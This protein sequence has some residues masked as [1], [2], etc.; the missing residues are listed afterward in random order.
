M[1]TSLATFCTSP[2]LYNNSSSN[3]WLKMTPFHSSN[4]FDCFWSFV[5]KSHTHTVSLCAIHPSSS[6]S[7]SA[8]VPGNSSVSADQLPPLNF[9]KFTSC[10]TRHWNMASLSMPLM[11]S[12]LFFSACPSSANLLQPVGSTS[13]LP[14]P[15]LLL[16]LTQLWTLQCTASNL[17]SL[18][19]VIHSYSCGCGGLF[20]HHFF[21]FFPH[22]FQ[23]P[24]SVI[25]AI[26]SF[27]V[28]FFSVQ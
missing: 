19:W 27:F 2:L 11:F 3:S 17:Y 15:L 7:S 21:F 1:R 9:D 4:S 20:V 23:P 16:L 18:N 25:S 14:R 26:L 28:L 12:S 8:A 6:S 22:S 24:K 5:S 10:V 13:T